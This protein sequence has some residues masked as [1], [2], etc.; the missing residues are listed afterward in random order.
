MAGTDARTAWDTTMTLAVLGA[1]G[2]TGR[3]LMDQALS[4]GN[5]VRALVRRPDAIAER[6]ASLSVLR[7][8]V[9]EP[10]PRATERLATAFV[11]CQ[12]VF[13]ALGT[14]ARSATPFYS[15]AA[16]QIIA[17]MRSAGVDR[18]VCMSAAGLELGPGVPILERVAL[19]LVVQRLLR[20]T[21]ADLMLRCVTTDSGVGFGEHAALELAYPKR[22]TLR[23]VARDGHAEAR[24]S[25]KGGG[26]DVRL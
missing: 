25:R 8:D 17:A 20:H 24:P 7:Y 16:R 12:A 23:G 3:H 2:A 22:W 5:Q 10:D 21:Y 6:P 26:A 13:S 18:L 11:G 4:S 19:R 15:G 14:S 9:S 1:T